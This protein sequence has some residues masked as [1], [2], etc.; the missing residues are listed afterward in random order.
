MNIKSSIVK[1]F[2]LHTVAYLSGV[3][4]LNILTETI[5]EIIILII[6][7]SGNAVTRQAISSLQQKLEVDSF[8]AEI[9]EKY[10][11]SLD[12]AFVQKSFDIFEVKDRTIYPESNDPDKVQEF[13]ISI[14][15]EASRLVERSTETLVPNAFQSSEEWYLD[16]LELMR[17]F[18]IWTSVI[19]GNKKISGFYVSPEHFP[20]SKNKLR[21]PKFVKNHLLFL[22]SHINSIF[23]TLN[24][25][26][27]VT[28]NNLNILNQG[29]QRKFKE[30][31]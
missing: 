5:Q 11:I 17:Y 2:Y 10:K 31:N 19:Q 18:P 26:E 30:A 22:K 1:N 21:V 12:N 20:H 13:I 28:D 27:V 16:F 25:M 9:M 14:A 24:Q 8:G 7:P 3:D 23:E 4:N 29:A 6:S 15:T